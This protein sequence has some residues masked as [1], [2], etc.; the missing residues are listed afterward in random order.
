MNI[1]DKIEE[2][3]KDRGCLALALIDPDVKNQ[4]KIIEMVKISENSDIDAI[5]VGGS[6]MMDEKFDLR[7]KQIKDSTDLPVIIFPG[8]PNQVSSDADAILYLS[9]I[10]GR[11]P[12]YLIGAH[13]ESA[14]K[15]KKLK[16]E[17][18]PTAYI[19]LDGGSKTS[20]QIISNTDPLPMDKKNIVL[21][22]ALAGQYLGNKLLY[23]ETG[24]GSLKHVSYDLLSYLNSNIDIPIIVGGGIN[25]LTSVKKLVDAGASYIVFG[26]YI[27]NSANIK[28]LNTF[29][30]AIH[31]IK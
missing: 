12:Q 21:A 16:I 8:S 29:T 25:N 4:K 20:V 27:E 31:Y 23:L 10:S 1:F 24:S 18:I 5:L 14:P 11:N 19:L 13:V 22:H 2:K 28:T 17:A 7:L 30:N 9:L 26:S 6:L 15:I 3:R